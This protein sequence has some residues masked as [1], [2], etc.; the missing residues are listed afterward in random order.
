MQEGRSVEALNPATAEIADQNRAGLLK[1]EDV[2][3][4]VHV[5]ADE[6]VGIVAVPVELQ[7]LPGRQPEV[8]A[9]ADANLIFLRVSPDSPNQDTHEDEE[10][11]HGS[12]P[13]E[14]GRMPPTCLVPNSRYP[15]PFSGQ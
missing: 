10:S 13:C 5:L 15:A 14:R 3:R 7:D 8:G 11:I 1:K 6:Y 4:L 9:L 12:I 2:V